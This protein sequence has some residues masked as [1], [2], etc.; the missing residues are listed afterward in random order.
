METAQTQ[1]QAKAIRAD[2]PQQFPRW[3]QFGAVLLIGFFARGLLTSAPS[4]PAAPVVAATPAPAP[5]P[6]VTPTP[7]VQP[8]IMQQAPPT[9]VIQPSPAPEIIVIQKSYPN[10]TIVIER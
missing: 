6:V 10:R 9:V 4:V 1:K 7:V 2:Q 3:V 8:I 5:A